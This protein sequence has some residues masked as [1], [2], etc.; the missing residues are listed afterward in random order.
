MY[1]SNLGDGYKYVTEYT[2]NTVTGQISRINSFGKE[3]GYRYTYGK[4][5]RENNE[6]L[7]KSHVRYY[8][9]GGNAGSETVGAYTGQNTTPVSGTYKSYSFVGDKMMS[10]GN[11]TCVYDN[12][13]NPTTYLGKTATWKGRQL[14]SFNGNTFTYDGRGRRMSKNGI[15]YIYDSQGRV[16]RQSNGLE[17]FYDYEGIAACR[18]N[19]QLYLYITDGQGNVIALIDTN[20][21]EVVQYWYD[22]W[23]NH[24]VVDANGNEIT[25]LNH[26]GNLNPF[27]YRG[28]YY[29][30]ETG[31]YFL[32]TRYY[33]PEVG[34]F[35]NRDS[36][37][38]ADPQTINGLNLYTYCGNNPVMYTDYAG[39]SPKYSFDINIWAAFDLNG[40]LWYS[41][42]YQPKRQFIVGSISY[43]NVFDNLPYMAELF[44]SQFEASAVDY[45]INAFEFSANKFII[46]TA[47]LDLFSASMDIY[48]VPSGNIGIKVGS[49]SV[50]IGFDFENNSTFGAEIEAT[51]LT[52]GLYSEYVEGELLIGSV[53]A[54]FK[55]ENGKLKIGLSAGIGFNLTMKLW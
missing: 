43:Q 19:D 28:Y 14:T 10:Y 51:A 34:R 3:I 21:N 54:A 35:L 50:G 31:L 42:R 6:L 38:Y 55:F 52:V 20:G 48:G 25:S 33:D 4:L 24:K 15:L 27:R 41:G 36:V 13:G 26:L 49:A 46:G 18:Y 53:G 7:N 37:S 23:G 47:K 44:L 1:Y 32:Q 5:M 2:Y 17:F 30:V 8:D 45:A 40:A 39:N 12:M 9:D 16:I 22:A 11:L 29:D